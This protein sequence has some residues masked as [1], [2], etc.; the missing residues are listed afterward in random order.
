M[1]YDKHIK[2]LEYGVHPYPK[3]GCGGGGGFGRGDVIKELGG[4]CADVGE[5]RV[6][7]GGDGGDDLGV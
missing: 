7:C 2:L 1:L 4:G 5:S 3:G 6:V